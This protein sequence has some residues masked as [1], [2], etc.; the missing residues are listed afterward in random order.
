MIKAVISDLGKVIIF[1]DNHIFFKKIE[2]HSSLSV[3]EMADRMTENSAIIRKFDTGMLDPEEFYG[4]AVELLQVRISRE[5]FFEI[6]NDIFTLNSPVLEIIKKLKFLYRLIL[7]SNTDEMRFGFIK[8]RFPEVLIFDDYVV[9]YEQGVMKPDRRIY[10]AA[11]MRA[12]TRED[13]CVFI[14]DREENIL[15]ADALGI[16]TIH[17]TPETELET[18]LRKHGLIF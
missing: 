18:A 11:L 14:D 2:K 9:S 7:L 12:Q 5:D 17:F 13:E 1:F 10:K 8:T 3:D 16:K 4:Q 6:Y 15:V